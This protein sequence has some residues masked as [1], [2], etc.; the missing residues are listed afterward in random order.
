[1]IRLDEEEKRTVEA[2]GCNKTFYATTLKILE[3]DF[4]SPLI[5]AHSRLSSVLDKRQIKV[6]DKI[7]LNQFHQ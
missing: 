1:M 4:N 3:R 5:V 6:N 7:S 2:I